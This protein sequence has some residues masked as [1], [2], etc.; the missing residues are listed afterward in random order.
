MQRRKSETNND[1]KNESHRLHTG[2]GTTGSGGDTTAGDGGEL[3]LAVS[4]HL[5][6]GLALKQK[7]QCKSQLNKTSNLYSI[8]LSI[9]RHHLPRAQR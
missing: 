8:V 2:R 1:A 3:L 7:G 9:N 5:F 6:E 4:D